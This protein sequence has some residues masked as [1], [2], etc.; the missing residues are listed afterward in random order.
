MKILKVYK[1]E[2]VEEYIYGKISGK[3]TIEMHY[4]GV[5]IV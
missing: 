2:C 1:L 4:V 5:F 3:V